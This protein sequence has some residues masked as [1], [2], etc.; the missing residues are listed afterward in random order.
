MPSTSDNAE[1]SLPKDQ[2][3]HEGAPTEWWWHTGSLLAEDGRKFGFEI[4]AT[5]E[6]PYGFTQ[7]EI[8][9]VESQLH[10]Q[11]VNFV[12]ALPPDWAESDIT[13]RWY[14]NLGGSIEKREDGAISMQAIDSN[15]LNMNVETT[16]VDAAT[17]T[18]C[19]LNLQ[20]YQEGLP[21]LVWGTGCR[22]VKP[23]GTTPLT[24]NNY[25]YSLTRLKASGFLTIGAEKFA[26][27]GLTWMDH[28][29]G[30][31]PKGAPVIWVLQDMQLSNGVHLSNFTNVGIK[32][33]ENVKM[34][35]TATLLWPD[36]RS[37]YVDTV[38][39]PLG[40]PFISQKNVEYY[41][42][43]QV[44]ISNPELKASFVVTSLMPDQ[45]F[46]DPAGSDVYEGVASCEGEFNNTVVSGT[47]WIEQS[48]GLGKP[49]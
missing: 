11:K 5:G 48:L 42:Q 35:S 16:F 24:R 33:V 36:G 23:D 31:F 45:L 22:E 1:I 43:F 25:Y 15:P 8:T 46:I 10:Y 7:I 28:E 26:V 41:L 40:S 30:F 34:D 4:N 9:D 44:E 37:I 49:L 17:H 19:E 6:T 2:Y 39:T 38:T 47:A 32:P 14:V 29:Y 13:K 21:L 12:A 18:P 3:A 20:L 27:T